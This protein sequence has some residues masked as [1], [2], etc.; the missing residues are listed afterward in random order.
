[1]MNYSARCEVHSKD[2][3]SDEEETEI[4]YLAFKGDFFGLNAKAVSGI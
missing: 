4:G 1:M 2:Y 3:Y